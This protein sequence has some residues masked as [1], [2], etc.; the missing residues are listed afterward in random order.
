MVSH[1]LTWSHLPHLY[2]LKT[3]AN[4]IENEAAGENGTGEQEEQKQ[5]TSSRNHTSS[6]PG[7]TKTHQNTLQ[8]IKNTC[9]IMRGPTEA[10]ES[11]NLKTATQSQLISLTS[12]GRP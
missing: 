3:P 11:Q 1:G 6:H 2:V 7:R 9:S 8:H 10:L 12:L 4:H 5:E